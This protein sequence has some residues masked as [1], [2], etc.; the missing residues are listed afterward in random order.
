MRL[1]P[2][3]RD[4]LLRRAVA[5]QQLSEGLAD[6]VAGA[7]SKEELLEQANAHADLALWLGDHMGTLN[8]G[9]LGASCT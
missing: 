9:E 1:E 4:V 5:A 6:L 2:S 8:A 7:D 3:Q